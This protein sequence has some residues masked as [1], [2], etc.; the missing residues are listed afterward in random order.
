MFE[1]NHSCAITSNII[2]FL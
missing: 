1:L 2:N